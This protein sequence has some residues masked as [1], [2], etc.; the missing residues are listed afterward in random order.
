MGVMKRGESFTPDG[1]LSLDDLRELVHETVSRPGNS[2]IDI[3]TPLTDRH[4]VTLTVLPPPPITDPEVC[5]ICGQGV[6]LDPADGFH[7]HIGPL[8]DHVRP[9]DPEVARPN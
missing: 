4:R 6:L 7:L 5:L 8:P 1:P 9:H 2:L 3:R